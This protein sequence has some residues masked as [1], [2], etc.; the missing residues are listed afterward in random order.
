MQPEKE[1]A[2]L[3]KAVRSLIR[4]FVVFAST[5]VMQTEKESAIPGKA[6][7]NAIRVFVMLIARTF[8]R[9]H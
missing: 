5:L 1:Y 3:G 7:R 6:V 4:I 9:Q 8:L 2:I